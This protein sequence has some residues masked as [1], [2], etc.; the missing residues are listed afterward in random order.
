MKMAGV[1]MW[2]IAALLSI[3]ALLGQAPAQRDKN[4]EPTAVLSFLILKDDNG[5]PARNA[6]VIMHPVSSHGKQE[7]AGLELT[8]HAEGKTSFDG[9]PYGKLSP[10]ALPCALQTF[11]YNSNVSQPPS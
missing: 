1:T 6:A 8:T 3:F 4:E 5:K 11:A 10:Q 7:R 2:T 9:I